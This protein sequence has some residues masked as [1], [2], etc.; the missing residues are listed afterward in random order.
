MADN[1]KKAPQSKK[2]DENAQVKKAVKKAAKKATKKALKNRGVQIALIVLVVLIITAIV[3]VYLVKPEVFDF[4]LHPESSNTGSGG[5]KNNGTGHVIDGASVVATIIDV[6]QGDGIY[7]EFPTG[8][9]MFID[10]GTEFGT[11]SRWSNITDVF[12]ANNVTKLDYY[13]ISHLDYDHIRYAKQIC[14]LVEIKTFYIPY[15]YED[16]LS[17]SEWYT[18]TWNTAYTAIKA[19]TYTENSETKASTINR[20]VGAWDLGGESWVMHCYSYDQADYVLPVT[21]KG[22]ADSHHKNSISPVCF[23]QYGGR[24]LCLTGDQNEEG[25]TY[26]NSKGYFDLY[27]IDVLKVAHHGSREGT[28]KDIFLDKVDPEYA[29]ISVGAENGYGHPHVELTQRLDD[30]KDVTPD[31]DADGIQ[32][33]FKTS[34][35]GNVTVTLA[36]DGKISITSAKDST[37]NVVAVACVIY[38]EDNNINITYTAYVKKEEGEI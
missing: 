35:D 3:V 20:N 6:G 2:V 33:V 26:L 8:E 7:I 11:S 14:D 12:T 1:K 30:Y 31:A 32:K 38:Q 34:E 36:S 21:S 16:H 19:E 15:V 4:I 9:N 25:E 10:G 27:D 5:E 18:S 13:M 24:T 17:D 22:K 28:N 29:I 37:K 23:L